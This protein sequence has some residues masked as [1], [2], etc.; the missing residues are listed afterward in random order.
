M[1]TVLLSMNMGT[2]TTAIYKTGEG[3]VLLEPSL[4]AVSGT[5]KNKVIK[6]VGAG[7]KKMLGRSNGVTVVSPVFEGRIVDGEMAV[8]MLKHFI[9]KVVPG[10]IFRPTIKALICT[11][12][13][14]TA[15]EKSMLEKVCYASGIGEVVLVPT[16]ITTA[17]GH[18]LDIS[19]SR[20]RCVAC[21][22]GGSTNIAI[23]SLNSILTGID[24]GLGGGRIDVAIEKYIQET[25]H[26]NIGAGVAENI[27]INIGSLY[28]NDTNSMEFTGIDQ[29]T[30]A[31]KSQ[32]ITSAELYPIISEFYDMVAEAIS[33][34]LAQAPTDII[35]D[36]NNEGIY[37]YGGAFTITGAENFMRNKLHCNIN[38]D[39]YKFDADVL[40][41]SML[42]TDVKLLKEIQ[43]NL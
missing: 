19:S 43:S 1:A 42:L 5:G 25:Y 35:A 41:G 29:E 39:S 12:I 2:S 22:G 26:I 38:V 9:S 13:G 23:L 28:P 10:K 33:S 8:V 3:V 20:G 11:P 6:A 24:I 21:M 37:L 30:K 16:I 7:A 17:L 40:G 32:T 36:I 31:T 18:S 34:V 27:K 14:L 4:V 15:T